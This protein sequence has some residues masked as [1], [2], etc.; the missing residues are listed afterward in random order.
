VPGLFAAGEV[1]AGLHGA[2]VSAATPSPTNVFGKLAGE[3]AAAFVGQTA[4]AG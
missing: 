2:T 3:H 1:A 4:Q